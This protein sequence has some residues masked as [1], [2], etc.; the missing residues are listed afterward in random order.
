MRTDN[1][2]GATAEL[3]RLDIFVAK[4]ETTGEIN[5]TK[6]SPAIPIK[7]H[8]TYKWLPG[9]YFMIHY[10]DVL[11]GDDQIDSTEIIGYDPLAKKY[12]MH[13][14]GYRGKTG[15]MHASVKDNTWI[16][17]GETER[18]T[19]SFNDSANTMSGTWERVDN[20]E[21]KFWMSIKLRK[22]E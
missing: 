14:F 1:T 10:V 13:Y 21:W 19:G 12:P 8:D 7:G 22:V 16:F 18:F 9:G 15:I 5:A 2:T 6:T 17:N 4:W 20:S 3:K 11:M